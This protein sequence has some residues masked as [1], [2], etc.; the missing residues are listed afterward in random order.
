[1]SNSICVTVWNEYRHEKQDE[2]IGRLY[3]IGIHGAIAEGLNAVD[4]ITATTATTQMSPSTDSPTRSSRTPMFVWWGHMAHGE[5]D[6]AVVAK[7]QARVLEGAGSSSSTPG[8]SRRSS[9]A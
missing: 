9:S 1:M 7:V 6:D 5:V 4:G 2:H 3:P 8:T